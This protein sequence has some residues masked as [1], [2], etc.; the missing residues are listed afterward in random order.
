[1][2]QKLA[3]FSDNMHSLID[4]YRILGKVRNIDA[5]KSIEETY[6]S[7]QKQIKPNLIFFMGPPA[8]GKSS[9]ALELSKKIKYFYI[10]LDLFA[11]QNK[12]KDEIELTDRLIKYLDSMPYKNAIIDNFFLDP[13]SVS[14]FFK[15]FTEPLYIFYLDSPKDEVYMNISKYY[16]CDKKKAQLKQDYERYVKTRQDILALIKAKPYFKTIPAV[17]TIQN[18]VHKIMDII[19]PLLLVTFVHHNQ[20]LGESY[21]EQLEK[22]RGFVYC[23][24]DQF[25]EL[26]T[27]RNTKVSKKFQAYIMQGQKPI[28]FYVILHSRRRGAGR[29]PSFISPPKKN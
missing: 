22:E 11:K 6:L 1:M 21:C 3:Q 16:D 19:K 15:I 4:T 7:V 24:I 23:D 29:L 13:K 12:C 20:D 9:C 27:E 17:D 25:L 10:S 2:V 18:I 26:E 5:S 8:V 14:V 28:E